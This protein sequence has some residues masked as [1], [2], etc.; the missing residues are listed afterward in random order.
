MIIGFDLSLNSTGICLYDE[1]SNEYSFI[2]NVNECTLTGR[3]VAPTLKE[4]YA[5][6][7][8]KNAFIRDLAEVPG[9]V[10]DSHRRE[11][12]Q[13]VG[14]VEIGHLRLVNVDKLS[15]SI[16][17]TLL[18][19][20]FYLQHREDITAIGLEDYSISKM[21]DDLVIVIETSAYLKQQYLLP[22]LQTHKQ[23]FPIPGPKI[24][25][26]AGNGN[27]DK[28]QML[29][30]FINIQDPAVV[31]TPFYQ[32]VRNNLETIVS[33]GSKTVSVLSPI[34][35]M[36]DAFWVV[37]YTKDIIIDKKEIPKKPKIK[38]S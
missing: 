1:K 36:I 31:K 26:L 25:M 15:K 11:T 12:G 33:R 9:V 21:T 7:P 16:Y 5:D 32:Y 37:K 3:K 13:G 24:K 8:P 30:A 6:P 34:P 28:F 10:I 4:F 23:M 27:N 19:S 22:L 17:S 29:M 14:H 2:A 35:D 20:Q 18:T 38:K